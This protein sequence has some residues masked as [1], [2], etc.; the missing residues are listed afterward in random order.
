M[1]GFLVAN[2]LIIAANLITQSASALKSNGEDI[3]CVH[4]SSGHNDDMT[5][6]QNECYR[7][8][9]YFGQQNFRNVLFPF[10]SVPFGYDYCTHPYFG[11]HIFRYG[12]FGPPF[13]FGNVPFR[14]PFGLSSGYDYCT[15]PYFGQ[16][17]F[18]NDPFELP[19]P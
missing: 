8:Q 3:A 2:T 12:P 14:L 13:P 17:I 9:S 1:I 4:P 5:T 11:Q 15:H 19:F 6:K 18:R 10:G 7:T 16:H